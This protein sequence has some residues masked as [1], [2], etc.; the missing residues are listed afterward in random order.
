MELTIFKLTLKMVG[1]IY[2][3]ISISSNSVRVES[4]LKFSHC[5][6][7]VYWMSFWT[8]WAFIFFGTFWKKSTVSKSVLIQFGSKGWPGSWGKTTRFDFICNSVPSSKT[9]LILK[10]LIPSFGWSW[11]SAWLTLTENKSKSKVI[12]S[13]HDFLND[14]LWYHPCLN[15]FST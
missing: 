10:R 12:W 6:N 13:Y 15:R 14:S 8:F 5:W 9:Y 1:K 4:S 11:D 2:C 3:E 7:L